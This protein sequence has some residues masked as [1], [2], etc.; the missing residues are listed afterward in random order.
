ML[1]SVVFQVVSYFLGFIYLRVSVLLF[2]II[3]ISRGSFGCYVGVMSLLGFFLVGMEGVVSCSFCPICASG[4]H[5]SFF[6]FWLLS[7]YWLSRLLSYLPIL[8]PILEG[9]YA[10]HMVI[11]CLI[12][13]CPRSVSIFY[14]YDHVGRVVM[15]LISP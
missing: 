14:L 1:I 6:I 10:F 12:H 13:L 9:R 3:T 2:I 11:F 4:L 5:L 7:L 15:L 8:R